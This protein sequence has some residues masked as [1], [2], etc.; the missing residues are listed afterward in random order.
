MR[1][2]KLTAVK[3]YSKTYS[4]AQ[5]F[6]CLSLLLIVIN[7]L[8]D[9][10]PSLERRKGHQQIWHLVTKYYDQR[11]YMKQSKRYIIYSSALR[12]PKLQLSHD[13]YDFVKL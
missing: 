12:N 9:V 2:N 10:S 1:K 3:T 5:N 7:L 13:Y 6:I 8:L 11:L 4:D